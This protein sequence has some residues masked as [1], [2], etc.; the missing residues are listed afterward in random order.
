[1]SHCHYS[2]NL[3]TYEHKINLSIS[4][5]AEHCAIPLFSNIIVMYIYFKS[6]L[7][8]WIEFVL[9]NGL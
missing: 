3:K 9:K 1:M 2:K 6:V 5:N 8:V 4:T 7:S